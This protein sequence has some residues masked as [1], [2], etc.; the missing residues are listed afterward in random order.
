M[1]GIQSKLFLC[2]TLRMSIVFIAPDDRIGRTVR[3]LSSSNGEK[4]VVEQGLLETAI[5]I[6][7]KY[8]D[9]AEVFV[10]RGGT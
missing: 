2:Y 4:I 10:S 9:E 6:A 5:P 1:Q 3:Q 7:R 8:L